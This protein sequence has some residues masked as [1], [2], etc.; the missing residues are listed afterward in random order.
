M[1][2]PTLAIPNAIGQIFIAVHG[3]ILTNNSS[4]WSHCYNFCLQGARKMS[5]HYLGT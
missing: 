5:S 4:I 1:F 2:E 3:Q